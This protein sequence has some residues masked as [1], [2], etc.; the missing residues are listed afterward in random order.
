[1]R[2]TQSTIPTKSTRP[3][4]DIVASNVHS[5]TE[6]PTGKR[7]KKDLA[8]GALLRRELIGGHQLYRCA[9]KNL[10]VTELAL[11]AHHAAEREA[12]DDRGH[13]SACRGFERRFGPPR[14]VFYIVVNVETVLMVIEEVA[15]GEAIKFFRRNIE[16]GVLHTERIKDALL[17]KSAERLARNSRDQHTE[18]VAANVIHPPHTRLRHRR[19][20]AKP[21]Q[22]FFG[23]WGLRRQGR[24]VAAN[25]IF[26]DQPLYRIGVRHRHDAAKPHAVRQ[27]IANG[28]RTTR[29]H[30]IIGL[31]G[32]RAQHAAMR[33]LRKPGVDR[34]VEPHLAL[35]HQ[36]RSRD[37]GNR[38][39]K[40]GYAKYRIAL[41]WRRLVERHCP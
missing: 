34:F 27:E 18:H 38:F 7:A 39:R 9:G 40:R 14:A 30:R 32:Y 36:N 17:H 37:R 24:P 16:P 33:K 13:E 11:V 2:S 20:R 22:P 4:K 12:V 29:R 21:S 35:F 15:R 23:G 5:H 1:G 6:S 19:Q 25:T 41:H 28:D 26:S 31:R 3:V 8:A 10:L